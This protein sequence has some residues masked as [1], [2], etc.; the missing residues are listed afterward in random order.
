VSAAAQPGT[1]DARWTRG[2]VLRLLAFMTIALAAT[3]VGASL[4]GVERVS[5]G[6]ALFDRS[7]VDATILGTARLPRVL[8]AALIGA[9][10][11][12]SGVDFQALLGNPLADPY[13]LGISGGAAAAGTLALVLIGGTGLS[14]AIVLPGAA[15]AGAIASIALVLAFGRVRGVLVP[16]VALLA[17]VVLNALASA[18][19]VGIRMIA[20]PSAANEALYW[21]TGSIQPV[22]T[23][24][25]VALAVYITLGLFVLL[26][27]AIA[28]NALLLGGDSAA[29]LGVDVPRTRRSIFLAA[30]LLTGGAV[31]LA[32]PI[33]F[34]GIVVP[35]GLRLL[36]GAD[37]RALLPASAIGG[38]IFLVL[39][40]M[41]TR[42]SFLAIGVEPT[43]GVLTAL[44][45]APF[46]LVLLRRRGAEGA[47]L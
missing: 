45:G 9:A 23:P 8:L 27:A 21:L 46:F 37:H 5:L 24:Q 33:G 11:A 39:A 19:I 1:L 28:M 32:G 10:L 38:A 31:A 43:V 13:V 25:L 15:F 18:L 14:S 26:R 22:A 35:H 16:T 47:P 3:L 34:V 42:L 41:L 4:V 17:G 7:S 30:S 12:P 44:I 29:S 40:D 20:R 36:L 2:R 6:R